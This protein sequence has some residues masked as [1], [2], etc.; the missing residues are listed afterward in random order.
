MYIFTQNHTQL[1]SRVFYKKQELLTIHEDLGLFPL[2]VSLM[3][4]EWQSKELG[5]IFSDPGFSV[6]VNGSDHKRPLCLAHESTTFNLTIRKT[7]LNYIMYCLF[8]RVQIVRK[9]E[10]NM[11]HLYI[12][13]AIV[14]KWL[15]FAKK[16]KQKVIYQNV[17]L[18][19]KHQYQ[20]CSG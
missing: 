6:T 17:I 11:M 7:F 9:V 1:T 15:S 16:Y 8:T 12:P 14:K 20:R 10:Q 4:K 19:L 13:V 18:R 5:Q 3:I 2:R